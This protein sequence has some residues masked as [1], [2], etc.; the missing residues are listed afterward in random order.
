MRDDLWAIKNRVG[1]LIAWTCF[2]SA[3]SAWQAYL[4]G[5][6]GG[7]DDDLDERIRWMEQGGYKAVRVRLTEI[8]E[9]AISAAIA[10]ATGEKT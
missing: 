10:A 5:L 4:T 7:D 9:P 6:M 3:R 2:P 8:E 1:S